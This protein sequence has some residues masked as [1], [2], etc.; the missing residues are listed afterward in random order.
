MAPS[1]ALRLTHALSPAHR[2]QLLRMA[3]EVDLPPGIRLFD[4]GGR[5]DRFW[6]VRDGTVAL[7]LHV[8]GHRTPV[9]ETVGT[10]D[11]VG[12]SWLFAPYAWQLGAYT[13][14]RVTAYEFDAVAVRLLCE[15]DAEF[16]R[17]VAVWLG[18]VLS[19]RLGAARVRLVDLY[20]APAGGEGR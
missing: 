5:A 4:E 13:V 16:G 10:G 9:I 20:G 8:P 19:Q 14:T 17:A 11:L 15:D 6:I 12:W 3:R 7:D 18:R 2:E 1:I